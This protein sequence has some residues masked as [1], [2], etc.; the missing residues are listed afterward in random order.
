MTRSIFITGATS[1]FGAATARL[2]AGRGWNVV[3]TGRRRDRLL[4]LAGAFEPG[5]VH[6]IEMDLADRDSIARA[7]A[8]LPIA[9]DSIDCL[10][11][12]GGLALGKGAVPDIREDD[13][14]QMVET[15]IMGLLHTTLDV[16][17]RLKAA[18]PGASIVNTG[19]VAARFPYAGGNA[20]GATK[21]FVH[22]FSYNLR[23][24]LAQ[25]G[26]RVTDLMPGMAKTEF[27][28]VRNYGDMEANERFYDGVDPIRPEDVADIVWFLANLP[29]HL[30][31]NCLE[32]MPVQQ[33]PGGF[34]VNRR[35]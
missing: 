7:V 10:F 13:W 29:A 18:G 27:T 1:G 6:A 5:R 19:S 2:F 9:F 34:A 24:D 11:N 28:A 32:L 21:A 31:V 14:R 3:A 23:I 15:N 17:P 25:T 20:Y 22:Q 30:N 16:L 35:G 33:N 8:G 12:N 26:I 4:A